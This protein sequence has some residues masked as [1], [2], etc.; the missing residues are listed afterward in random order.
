MRQHPPRQPARAVLAVVFDRDG[1]AAVGP[2]ERV[3]VDEAVAVV[4]EGGV[5]DGVEGREEGLVGRGGGE[6]GGRGVEDEDEG[7]GGEGDVV[8]FGPL[9]G[10]VGGGGGGGGVSV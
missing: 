6:G 9:E 4:E 1:R 2:R 7:E 5:V 10:A 8:G 3:G